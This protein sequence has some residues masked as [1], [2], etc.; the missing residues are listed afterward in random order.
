MENEG[1]KGELEEKCEDEARLGNTRAR[2]LRRSN[3]NDELWLEVVEEGWLWNSFTTYEIFSSK[4]G[5]EL[6]CP[7]ELDIEVVGDSVFRVDYSV[8][9]KED[10]SGRNRFSISKNKIFRYYPN[11]SKTDNTVSGMIY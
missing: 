7:D 1:H 2:L 5:I 8:S 11:E 4:P 3:G 9:Y 10:Y 6:Q